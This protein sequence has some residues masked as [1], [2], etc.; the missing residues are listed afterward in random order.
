[1]PKPEGMTKR[2]KVRSWIRKN[3]DKPF[4]A[5][6]VAR[7]FE[8][9]SSTV[10][11]VIRELKINGYAVTRHMNGRNTMWKVLKPGEKEE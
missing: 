3:G 10:T 11:S 7:E 6:D 1:M 4:R 2:G 9:N 8:T 5:S